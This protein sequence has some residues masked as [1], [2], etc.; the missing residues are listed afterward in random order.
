MA[1]EA[2]VELTQQVTWGRKREATWTMAI[3]AFMLTALCPLWMH[4]NWITLEF[5]D[6]SISS[7]ANELLETGVVEFISH[8][9]PH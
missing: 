8:Y 2:I 3:G 7:A 6:G 9:R 4:M 5:F 1:T